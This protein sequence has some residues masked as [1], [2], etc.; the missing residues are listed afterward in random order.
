MGRSKP[1]ESDRGGVLQANHRLVL[2]LRDKKHS[3][4]YYWT[5]GK[6]ECANRSK[7]CKSNYLT[8]K[9]I[10]PQTVIALRA[11]HRNWVL[12]S[13]GKQATPLHCRTTMPVIHTGDKCVLCWPSL[14]VQL[15]LPDEHMCVL[16]VILHEITEGWRCNSTRNTGP[17]LWFDSIYH[18]LLQ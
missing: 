8:S 15:L 12:L 3:S 17:C 1:Q 6:T 2:S 13:W 5:L 9:A 7:T 18:P 16:G 14:A 10:T 11:P 4:S